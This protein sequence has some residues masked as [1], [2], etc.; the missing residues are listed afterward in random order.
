MAENLLPDYITHY[1]LPDRKPF[2]S[3]SDLPEEKLAIV[4]AE[5][6]DNAQR[7]ETKRGFASWY[8][9]ER[10]KTEVFLRQEFIKK[11]GKPQRQ[12]PIYFVLGKSDCQK[13][14]DPVQVE[15]QLKLADIPSE[16]I[17]FTYPDSMA[18]M[19]LRDD[20]PYRKPYHGKVF[21]Y[22]EIIEV[23]KEHG[24]PMDE[25]AKTSKFMYPNYIEVQLWS[26][27]PVKHFL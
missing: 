22:Q 6:R 25:A 9:E 8:I 11:G 24:F 20:L 1:H 2:L 18:T 23:V 26:D 16:L 4:L 13:R 19:V 7:G 12:Y 17:S 10:K 21:T 14:M 3:L 15:I 5:L 27:E